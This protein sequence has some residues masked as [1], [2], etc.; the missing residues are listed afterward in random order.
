MHVNCVYVVSQFLANLYVAQY[1]ANPF[2]SPTG[3][4]SHQG[5]QQDISDHLLGQTR[6]FYLQF[7]GY[8]YPKGLLFYLSHQVP[9]M[10]GNLSF[11]S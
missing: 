9:G 10:K 4:S 5:S 1:L 7:S 2:L 6:S 11:T 3:K 8:N